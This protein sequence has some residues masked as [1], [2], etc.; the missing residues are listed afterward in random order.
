MSEG[1]GFGKRKLI[2]D[3]VQTTW[4]NTP[5]EQKAFSYNELLYVIQELLNEEGK[6]Y[7]EQRMETR[8]Y[9]VF[10]HFV[11]HLLYRNLANYDSMI[12][13][14]AEKGAGKSSAAIML[15]RE[16]CRLLGIK[17]SPVRH[18]AYNNADV[19]TKIDMLEKF[20]P[21]VCDEAI[22]FASSEDWAKKSNKQLKKKLAQVRTKHL[23]YIL[24]F[25]LKIYKLE[26]TYLESY[27]NYWCLTGDT[28]IT[29]KDINGT[30]RQTPIKDLNKRNPEVLTYNLFTKEFE[31]KKY[32]KKI[33]TKKNA[34]VYE[35]ELENGQK[36]KCTKEHKFLTSNGWKE[37][38][39][40][41]EG[42]DIIGI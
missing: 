20:E 3:I 32:D 2:Y 5:P 31:F 36:I 30:I 21:I 8:G 12:L 28:K 14:T 38:Q 34:E 27:A 25:P 16:W 41:K 22:R 26:K 17:F 15:A 37:L 39:E 19:L 9:N 10:R 6:K 18:I 4:Q 42:D 13:I 40:L 7:F 11:K 33:K 29:T 35:V 23:L 24:C 1:L